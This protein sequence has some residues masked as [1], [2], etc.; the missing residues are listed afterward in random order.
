MTL[1]INT[2]LVDVP[3]KIIEVGTVRDQTK[4]LEKILDQ[5][6]DIQLRQAQM[7]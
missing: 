1:D 3:I 6:K 2:V 7:I 4:E 5:I